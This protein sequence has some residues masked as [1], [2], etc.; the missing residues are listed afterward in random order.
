MAQLI[1]D[2]GPLPE[3]P[4]RRGRPGEPYGVLVR[5]ITGQQLSV[6]AADSIWQRV[7]DRF[8]GTPTPEQILAD[9]PDELRVACG[10]SRARSSTCAASP[11]TS[12]PASSSSTG[13][14]TCPTKRSCAS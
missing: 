14:R 6:K 8:G 11:S 2:G 13:C 7:V 1:A 4:G 3:R 12:S 10:F 9:D 5:A